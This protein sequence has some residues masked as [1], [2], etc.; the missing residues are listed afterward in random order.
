M[1]QR[2]YTTV[3]A[4]SVAIVLTTVLAGSVAAGVLAYSVV[5]ER[6]VPLP[7]DLDAA[8]KRNGENLVQFKWGEYGGP[9]LRIG[10]LPADNDSGVSSWTVSSPDGTYNFEGG[11]FQT[12]VP[13][14]AIDAM[15]QHV[16]IESDR[17]RVFERAEIDS[18]L[19][20]QDLG[21]SGRVTQQSAAKVGQMLGVDFLI[22]PVV[23]AYEPEF[24]KK[25]GGLGGITRGL[26]G[27]AKAGKSESMVQ[28]T[29]RLI[30]AETGEVVDSALVEVQVGK[31]T[32]GVAGVGWGGSGAAGGAFESMSK[33]PIGNAV[34]AA[35]N[36]GVY[37]MIKEIG[38][39]PASGAI[40]KVGD[41]GE[42]IISLNENA[43]AVGDTVEVWAKGEE[44]I[45]PETGESLGSD[46]EK[47]GTLTVTRVAEKFSY[48]T[49]NQIEP[50]RLSRGDRVVSTRT[51]PPME[52]GPDWKDG[53][54]PKG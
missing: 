46:D 27:G 24:K 40:V 16:M 35:V 15:V 42:I 32:F 18:V 26:F 6:E 51:P 31:V 53:K 1:R 23:N 36:C 25:G 30:D 34:I 54:P 44:L 43:V 49:P 12:Q 21:A 2:I 17:F 41:D 29:F 47:V 33:T 13:V 20:E 5:D 48:A 7:E 4:A 39:R 19:D 50:S 52:F 3:I 28:M 10:V 45:D 38:N 9:K 14:N 22:Q 11:D 37:E 8:A